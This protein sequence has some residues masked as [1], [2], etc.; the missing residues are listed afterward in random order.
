MGFDDLPEAQ[1]DYMLDRIHFIAAQ[2]PSLRDDTGGLLRYMGLE[3]I[4]VPVLLVE[5]GELAPGDRR[6]PWVNW[7]GGCPTRRG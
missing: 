3:S 1:R 7:R 5:G 4:G 6:D 2:G